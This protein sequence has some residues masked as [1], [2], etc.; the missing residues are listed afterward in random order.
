MK[1][2]APDTAISAAAWRPLLHH[3]LVRRIT[4]FLVRRF[5]GKTPR[6][7]EDTYERFEVLNVLLVIPTFIAVW[8]GP[9][10]FFRRLPQIVDGKHVLYVTPIKYL[11]YALIVTAPAVLWVYPM[12]VGAHG[13][14]D[15]LDET[16]PPGLMRWIASKEEWIVWALLLMFGFAAPIWIVP[17][18]S[19]LGATRAFVTEI[20]KN[21]NDVQTVYELS[22]PVPHHTVYDVAVA[23]HLYGNTDWRR[24]ASGLCYFGV[25]AF[26]MLHVV[27]LAGVVSALAFSILLSKVTFALWLPT[28]VLVPFLFVPALLG[29]VLIIRP[30]IELLR[31]AQKKVSLRIHIDDIEEVRFLVD[32]FIAQLNDL[33]RLQTYSDNF[34]CDGLPTTPERK[35][36]IDEDAQTRMR[37][38]RD[39][40]RAF[41]DASRRLSRFWWMQDFDARKNPA[42]FQKALVLG[43]SEACATRLRLALLEEAAAAVRVPAGVSG[44]IT[45]VVSRLRNAIVMP[46]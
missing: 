32:L 39:T 13:A 24:F 45:I 5:Q 4:S 26:L 9:R 28:I 41:Q 6:W 40:N 29:E 3:V 7:V 8:L 35:R 31:A 42:E 16:I 22:K 1:S 23:G 37:E 2:R 44:R 34:G 25:T 12:L 14:H 43:R 17:L 18:N 19:I 27:A 46:S 30:Y 20:R 33:K 10:H 36:G 15:L 21:A 11:S 38:I